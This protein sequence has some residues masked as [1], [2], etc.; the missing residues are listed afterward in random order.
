M[1]PTRNKE[2]DS[3]AVLTLLAGFADR[4][5]CLAQHLELSSALSARHV[6]QREKELHALLEKIHDD[7]QPERCADSSGLVV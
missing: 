3:E 2:Q 5:S 4:E 7:L 6:E 1:V